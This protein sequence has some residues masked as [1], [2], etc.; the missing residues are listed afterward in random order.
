MK[1]TRLIMNGSMARKGD[2][3]PGL[4]V[5]NA[6]ELVTCGG[7]GEAAEEKLGIV[8][9]GAFLV[10]DGKISWVGS[11]RELKRKPI[12][13]RQTIDARGS[14]VTPGFVD[15]HTHLAFAGSREDELAMKAR[16]ETYPEILS[17]GG[18]IVRTIKETRQAT[19]TRITAE[20]TRRLMQLLRN[21]VTTAEV[22]TGYGQSLKDELKLLEVTRR[23][24]KTSRVEIV[25]TFLGLHAKP[26]EFKSSRDYVDH[27]VKVMLPEVARGKSRPPFSDCFCEEGVFSRDE[28][29]RY[30]RASSALGFVCKVHAD[31]FSNTE[32][33]S[34]A[35]D[36]RCV[37]ADH[38]GRSI[39]AGIRKMARR[40]V[41]AVLLPGTSLYS[42]I[43]FAD[44]IG[45]REAGCRVALGTDLS[46]NSWIESPQFVMGLACT[47][48]RMT[49][50]E[51]LL[52]F[53][54]NAARAIGRNDLG[55]L[56]VGSSADFVIHSFP[57]YEFL[58][59]R[60]G[61][62]YTRKVFKRGVQA[63]TTGD[64]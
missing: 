9:D 22:K 48:M 25:P 43:P 37:S 39:P 38:L 61:G 27:V 63:F 50:A 24:Q 29:S 3:V 28:C 44:A 60:V 53:T 1:Q 55:S 11:S 46:P 57:G 32:G 34:L 6:G 51:A 62:Q 47:A 52:G 40:G 42:S 15:P 30:L 20:S 41:T 64:S 14:L 12:G 54:L 59:Y 7:I 23:L 18:G 31:E 10:D 33:A 2:S 58:P 13:R 49:P 45:I 8:E 19:A 56:T 4:A 35:A 21:G 5:I 36:T 17:Q 16:G 26:P